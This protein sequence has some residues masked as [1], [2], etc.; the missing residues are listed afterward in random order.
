MSWLT[1]Q[2]LQLW[3]VAVK[4]ALIYVTAVLV[5][6]F[7]QRRTMSQWPIIDFATAVAVGAVVGRTAIASD[8]SILTGAVAL[9]LS[10]WRTGWRACCGSTCWSPSSPTTRCGCSS[11]TVDCDA[12]NFGCAG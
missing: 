4:A 7:A 9:S 1:G 2:W 11:R 8:Q 12:A 5:L 6:R 10:S 3:E